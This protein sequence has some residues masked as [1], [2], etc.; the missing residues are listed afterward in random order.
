MLN[1]LAKAKSLGYK[2]LTL[3][4]RA[5]TPIRHAGDYY[6]NFACGLEDCNAKTKG[7]SASLLLLHLI[8]I[9]I[10][11]QTDKISES[12]YI[13]IRNEFKQIVS[14]IPDIVEQTKAWVSQNKHWAKAQS[15]LVIGHASNYGT[16]IEGALKV[17]ET[18]CVPAL[19]SDVDEYAHGY[20]RIL[21]NDS[22]IIAIEGNGYGSANMHKTFEYIR[23]ITPNRLLISSLPR[24][25][26]LN[27]VIWV[28][29]TE[30]VSSALLSVIV[31]QTLAVALPELIDQDPNVER[32]EDYLRSLKTRVVG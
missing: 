4:E 14:Q 1:C 7:Y 25:N 32:H 16:A 21:F 28:S 18:L 26:A 6:L 20:H 8:G 9:E 12:T 2:I 27:D 10:G 11:K 30:H 15:I 17:S 3:T 31:F 24:D 22:Y 23:T 29:E 19:F 5:D 13:D